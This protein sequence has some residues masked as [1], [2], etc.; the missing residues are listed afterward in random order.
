METQS[1]RRT[2]NTVRPTDR[3]NIQSDRRIVRLQ[4]QSD[5]QTVGLKSGNEI[6]RYRENEEEGTES[7]K[8]GIEIKQIGKVM[9]AGEHGVHTKMTFPIYCAFHAMVKANVE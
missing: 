3:Q 8:K 1:D 4:D 6:T 5:S 7:Q 9:N 2:G